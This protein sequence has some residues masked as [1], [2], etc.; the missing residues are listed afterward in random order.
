M[1]GGLHLRVNVSF[2]GEDLTAGTSVVG[3]VYPATR[4]GKALRGILIPAG[5]FVRPR[6]FEVVRRFLD[7]ISDDR[8]SALYV[9]A[10]TTGLRRGELLG[11]RW[12]DL[13]QSRL[14]VRQTL[15]SVA[16]KAQFS[17]PKT[18]RSRRTIALDPATLAALKTHRA[19]Q[20][21][22]RLAWGPAWSDTGLAFTRENGEAIH[23]QSLSDAFEA[24]VKRLGL[25]KLSLHGVRH[26][27]ATLALASG[28]KPW[29]LSDRL[30]HASIAFTLQ[31]YRHAIPAAQDAAAAFILG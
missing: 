13:E 17:E 10:A 1:N 24:H 21:A 31:V 18:K 3:N 5:D 29:D 2:R 4:K 16:Y 19:N 25:P 7:G 12:I 9:L 14:S 30:G 28:M 23:P 26:S 6:R 20:N 15:V 11:L 27:Y 22:E 8:L